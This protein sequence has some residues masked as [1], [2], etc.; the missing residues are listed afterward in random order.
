MRGGAVWPML[1]GMNSGTEEAPQPPAA[2]AAD[3][4][5]LA[6]QATVPAILIA[7]SVSHL[8]NDAIQALIPS[9][10]PLLKAS[11]GLTFTQIGLITF[12]FQMTGSVFQPLVGLY[13]DRNPKPYSLAIG[14]TVTLCGLIFLALA[15]N[16]GAVIAAA[17]MV[18]LGSSIFH[19]E[20][21]RIARAASGGR[22]GFAQSLFQTGGNAGSALGPLLAAWVVVPHGQRHILWFTLVALAGIIVLARV[23]GWYRRRLLAGVAKAVQQATGRAPLPRRT[24]VMALLILM[25]LV[26]SKYFYLVSMTSY[27]T[28]YMIG[29]F[30]VSVQESQVVLFAFLIAVAAGTIIGGPFGDRFGRK[31]VIWISILGMAP[32]SLVLPHVGFAGTVGLSIV[33][34]LVMASAFSAILVYATELVPGRVGMIAGLFFGLAFGAAGIGAALLGKLADWT[35]IDFVFQVC[36]F[37]PLLG[38]LTAFLPNLE[39]ANR[40]KAA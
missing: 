1:G 20:A 19:P 31:K 11:Y 13:T 7:L 22:H 38:L 29:K 17:A 9:I 18:G 16:Y 39:T 26:F 28:F 15:P 14:M 10:Y 12:T 6:A 4:L 8:L 23:G 35:S 36:A 3:P 27:Y 25:T 30:H 2:E 33:I 24:V 34:G 32:F 5:H 37:L 21:S 40:N